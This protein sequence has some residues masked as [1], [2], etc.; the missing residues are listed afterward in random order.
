MVKVN[1]T[2]VIESGLTNANLNVL[3]RISVIGERI[4]YMSFRDIGKWL[5][6]NYENVRYHFKAFEK[7]DYLTIEKVNSRR[8][9]FHLNMKKVKELFG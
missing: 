3:L 6:M 1:D 5:G 7:A 8:L 4:T 2:A 9:L